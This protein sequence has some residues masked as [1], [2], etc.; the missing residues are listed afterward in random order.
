MITSGFSRVARTSP[1]GQTGEDTRRYMSHV[2]IKAWEGRAT[3]LMLLHALESLFKLC[4]QRSLA[5][6]QSVS[7]HNAPQKIATWPRV[8]VIHRHHVF[9]RPAGHE[10]NDVGFRRPVYQF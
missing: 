1:S 10:N 9:G 5:G 3:L 8:C 4:H 2:R 6:L 7:S